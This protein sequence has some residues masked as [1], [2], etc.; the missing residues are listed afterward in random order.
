M[1]TLLRWLTLT[2]VVMALAQLM[3]SVS[4][5]SFI[6]AL[7]AALV[8]GLIMAL[9]KPIITFVAFPINLLTFGL[10][11]LVINAGLVLL[12]ASIVPGF[13]VAGFW[14]AVLF[15]FLLSVISSIISWI[16]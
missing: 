15:G 2:L 8:L 11:S 10:F 12:A 9:L 3:S 7:A 1:K 5:D 4:V 16:F 13:E 14:A 6:T